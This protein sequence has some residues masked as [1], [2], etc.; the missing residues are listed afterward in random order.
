MTKDV[1]KMKT[2]HQIY[3]EGGMYGVDRVGGMS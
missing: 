3:T 1:I 2:G